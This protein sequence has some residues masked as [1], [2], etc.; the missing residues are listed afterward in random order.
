MI[1][2][3]DP[4]KLP[5]AQ[6][7][8]LL[9]YVRRLDPQA[10]AEFSRRWCG[11]PTDHNQVYPPL[12][13]LTNPEPEPVEDPE[14]KAEFGLLPWDALEEV[15]KVFAMAIHEKY[16]PRDWEI[17]E[18]GTSYTDHVNSIGR[19]LK[20]W[21]HDANE[22]DPESG[23]HPMAHVAS[24]ALMVLANELRGPGARDDRP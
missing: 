15:A 22:S 12:Q 10:G 23:L 6:K 16:A 11:W 8:P 13:T 18:N 2:D 24:R 20:Q 1:D 19:H 9:D 14:F 7:D 4:R 3:Y 5:G 21:F 17:D